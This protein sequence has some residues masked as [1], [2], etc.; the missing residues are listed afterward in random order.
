MISNFLN[1]LRLVLWP[2]MWSILETIPCV[3]VN[4]YSAALGWNV[5][6]TC[7]K[8]TWPNNFSLRLIFFAD[9]LSGLSLWITD[10]SEKKVKVK[11]LS[12]VWLFVTSWIVVQVPL[13]MRFSRQEY[14]SGLPFL[15]PKD[16]PNS[17]IELR[18]PALQA[19]SLPSE[20]PG[21][22]FHWCNG[23]LNVPMIIVLLPAFTLDVLI[24]ALFIL[25]LLC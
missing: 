24:I 5:L 14:W 7:I 8:S 1:L 6:Y 3:L 17:G 2:N 22:L 20:L 9:F 15:S 21:N 10:V 4:V 13:S 16:L 23:V 18:C 12:H 25:M 11:L 19:D